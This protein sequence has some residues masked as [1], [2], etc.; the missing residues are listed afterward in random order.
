MSSS[1]LQYNNIKAE[2][3]R[4]RCE[5]LK[6][7]EL[8]ENEIEMCF[9]SNAEIGKLLA[10]RKGFDRWVNK[11]QTRVDFSIVRIIAGV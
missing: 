5:I 7:E 4:I 2:W 6:V 9:N 8:V 1:C 3:R 10:N 11:L